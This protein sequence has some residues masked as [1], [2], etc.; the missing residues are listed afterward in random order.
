MNSNAGS[1]FR[2]RQE[3]EV[4]REIAGRI[5]RFYEA[6]P[7]MDEELR[8]TLTILYAQSILTPPVQMFDTDDK[9]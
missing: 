9:M 1:A 8:G 2:Q 7:N 5:G 6:L 3:R 4:A